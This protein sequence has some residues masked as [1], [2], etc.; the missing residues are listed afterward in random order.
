MAVKIAVAVTDRAWFEQ[1]SALPELAEVNFW[2]ASPAPFT[3]L[4]AGELFLF[5]L[6]GFIVGGGVFVTADTLPCSLAWEVFGTANGAASLDAMRQRFGPQ[7]ARG[8]F[9][10][11]CR[12]LAQPFF[13]DES[14]WLPVPASFPRSA[15]KTFDTASAQ[16]AQLWD[17][18]QARLE[19]EVA[20][21]RSF[22]DEQRRYGHPVLVRPRLGQGAFRVLVTD[23]Y[24]RRCAVTRERTLPALEAAHIR[25]YSQGG[26]HA[27][28]NG[29]LL[30]RDIHSLFDLGYVSITPDLIF[31][32]SG[33][34]RREY[35]DGR[36][37]YALHGRNVVIPDHADC[38]ADRAALA[39]HNERVFLGL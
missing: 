14:F 9:N 6:D 24:A 17:A 29:I 33:R 2:T 36:D 25:P 28:A 12:V 38:R 31:V 26:D 15:Y 30:R 37:Y 19:A 21:E 1:L 3:A 5:A 7:D 27:P 11:S 32:V 10:I 35:R 8:D 34:I 23:A 16:G 20:A 39:W 18:V 13:W 4:Q 22:A